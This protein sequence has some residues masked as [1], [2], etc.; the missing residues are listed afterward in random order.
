MNA[1]PPNP[2]N[3]SDGFYLCYRCQRCM[4][5]ITKLEMLAWRV[6]NDGRGRG[7]ICPCGSGRIGASNPTPIERWLP[8]VIYLRLAVFA[9]PAFTSGWAEVF[10]WL[11]RALGGATVLPPPPPP[12]GEEVAFACQA[13]LVTS[14][15]DNHMQAVAKRLADA[16]IPL[17]E[18]LV[19]HDDE[20]ISK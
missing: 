2:T 9:S 18:A 12:S 19:R 16:D 10:S 11:W 17:E 14:A 15:I 1:I 4:R 5:L 13:K 7:S 6:D 8:R 20:E 3:P